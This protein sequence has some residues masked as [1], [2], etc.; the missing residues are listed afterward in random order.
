VFSYTYERFAAMIGTRTVVGVPGQLPERCNRMAERAAGGL[1]AGAAKSSPVSSRFVSST[2]PA[3]IVEIT[4]RDLR[5]RD[6]ASA[7]GIEFGDMA[8]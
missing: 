1:L 3:G 4:G 7:Q 6:A 2:D 8:R 5:E